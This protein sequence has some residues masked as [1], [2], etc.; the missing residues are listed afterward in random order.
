M[1]ADPVSSPVP[2]GPASTARHP[3][4][5]P[6]RLRTR[7][8]R[9]TPRRTPAD[10]LRDAL[11]ALGDWRGQVITHTE[12]AWASITFTGTRHTLALLFAGA[13][14]V[15]AGEVLVAELAEHEFAIPRQL[16][17][18]AAITEV[19]HRLLPTPRLVVQCELLLLEED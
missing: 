17:A 13:E 14:A 5:A 8:A 11:M 7:A 19:E 12:R 18:D 9:R 3:G 10:R 6:G 15:A 1:R 4:P 16:V 2:D